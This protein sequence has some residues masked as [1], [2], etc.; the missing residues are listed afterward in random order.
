MIIFQIKLF[1]HTN[2]NENG[3]E[4]QKFSS[5]NTKKDLQT[6]RVYILYETVH[7]AVQSFARFLATNEIFGTIRLASAE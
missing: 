3:N 1:F 5:N 7:I 4:I 6:M 2:T